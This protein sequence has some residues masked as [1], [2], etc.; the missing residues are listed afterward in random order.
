VGVRRVAC[1]WLWGRLRG[2][3]RHGI[4]AGRPRLEDRQLGLADALEKLVEP[5]TRGDPMSLLRW[6]C[7]SR[8]KLA[9]ALT[10]EGWSISSTT[11][12]RMLNELGYRLQSVNKRNEGKSDPDRNAQFEHINATAETYK[13]QGQPVIS[14]DTKKKELVG[15]FKNNGC[16]WQP[17]G[18]PECALVHDV[19]QDAIGKAI[20][21]HPNSQ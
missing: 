9:A 11:V 10:L 2:L 18:T 17:K 5:V 14:V 4:G 19:P 13:A 3:G 21:T 15:D 16:E 1:N 7:K 12:G 8:A 20:A 6:T